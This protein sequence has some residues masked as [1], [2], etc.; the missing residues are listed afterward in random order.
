VWLRYH[1]RQWPSRALGPA[2]ERYSHSLTN[3][4]SASADAAATGAVL[5]GL[6][7]DGVIPDDVDA[8][9]AEQARLRALLDAE[10]A[11]YGPY[12]YTDREDGATLRV[13]FGKHV[14][15][16]LSEA[17]PSY[18]RHVLGRFDSLPSAAAAA[19]REALHNSA[20][21]EA[22]PHQKAAS[23][24]SPLNGAAASSRRASVTDAFGTDAEKLAYRLAEGLFSVVEAGTGDPWLEAYHPDLR[25]AYVVKP[26]T[27]GYRYLNNV[28]ARLEG[29]GF[30]LD[31]ERRLW[32]RPKVVGG[33][34]SLLDVN[35]L[36]CLVDGQRWYAAAP[37]E[38]ETG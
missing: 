3:A 25:D 35:T 11:R 5:S 14:G 21:E 27:G 16:L 2:A 24:A 29:I 13:G 30:V 23:E 26:G 9:L 17:P 10:T 8:A 4:H 6:L 7:A 15:V 33:V 18:L 20:A 31:A 38:S 1:C 28:A 19:M 12:L 32:V 34:E 36:E 22:A 37:G